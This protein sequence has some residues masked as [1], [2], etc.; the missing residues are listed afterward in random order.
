MHELHI[1]MSTLTYSDYV[2]Y[3]VLYNNNN[4]NNNN[5]CINNN[6]ICIYILSV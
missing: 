4:N 2:I 6:N 3:H 5:I 1:T